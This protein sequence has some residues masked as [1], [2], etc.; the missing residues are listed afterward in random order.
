M[1]LCLQLF[2]QSFKQ[3]PSVCIICTQAAMFNI[4]P[5]HNL[6]VEIIEI[7]FN[8]LEPR[9]IKK[10]VLVNH[11]WRKFLL[12]KRYWSWARI[13]INKDNLQKILVENELL[14]LID[15]VRLYHNIPLKVQSLCR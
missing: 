8:Y 15:S 9:D 6:P 5:D 14:D 4:F 13:I 10:G 1:S 11:D 7:I 12:Q 2:L 3:R